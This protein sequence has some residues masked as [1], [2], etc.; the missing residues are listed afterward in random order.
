MLPSCGR[1][2]DAHHTPGP[3]RGARPAQGGRTE[4]P[5]L[6]SLCTR[7]VCTQWETLSPPVPKRLCK[8]AVRSLRESAEAI[9]NFAQDNTYADFFHEHLKKL[10][11]TKKEMLFKRS[12]A[13]YSLLMVRTQNR[14]ISPDTTD[15][16]RAP[17][18]KLGLSL[19]CSRCMIWNSGRIVHFST[20]YCH[21]SKCN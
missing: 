14:L 15:A 3:K 21:L 12:V 11:V 8:Y 18:D 5:G 9:N 1:K 10:R 6:S 7:Q 19:T 20:R 4:A 16:L 13:N 17:I 2:R